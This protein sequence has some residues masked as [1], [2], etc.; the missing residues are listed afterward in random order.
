M[1]CALTSILYVLSDN[2]G[3]VKLNKR[4]S[5]GVN[6]STFVHALQAPLGCNLYL[7]S[8]SST[9][10]NVSSA[11]PLYVGV[12][13][14][15]RVGAEINEISGAV[16]STVTVS[17]AG[18]ASQLLFP[19][20][21]RDRTS[22]FQVPS[23]GIVKLNVKVA[24]GGGPETGVKP[25]FVQSPQVLLVDSLYL[26]CTPLILVTK[27]VAVPLYVSVLLLV[28][29]GGVEINIVSGGAPSLIFTFTAAG[30]ALDNASYHHVPP[31][32]PPEHCPYALPQ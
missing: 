6:A 12:L 13:S 26:Y 32:Q 9:L 3:I 24:L 28:R 4:E 29:S 14:L 31:Q 10:L 15:V 30:S 16:V 23:V 19:M 7:Y 25:T 1:S 5:A 17:A 8:M 22:T 18:V 2:V 21:S 27:S 20:S 11:F